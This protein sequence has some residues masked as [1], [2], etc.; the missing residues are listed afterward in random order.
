[1]PRRPRPDV[2]RR[3]PIFGERIVDD[4][5]AEIAT[6]AGSKRKKSKARGQT[7]AKAVPKRAIPKRSWKKVTKPTRKPSSAKKVAAKKGSAKKVPARRALAR[8]LPAKKTAPVKT[9][10]TPAPPPSALAS[11][12]VP[13]PPPKTFAQK[14]RERD[15]GT[16]IWFI[17]AGSVEHA[18]IQKRGSDGVVVIV[19]DA[20]VTEVVPVGNL[21]ETA[22]EA[23][24]AR[25]R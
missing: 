10:P 9:R 11:P 20:G 8:K 5:E 6:I 21:F 16:G 12:K 1:M 7:R 22:D 14:V 17:T 13:A 15:A 2:G 25:Y 4:A 19:T 18:S 24:A 3:S 23:R